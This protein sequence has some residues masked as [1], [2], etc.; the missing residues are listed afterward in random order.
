M[1]EGEAALPRQTVLVDPTESDHIVIHPR[2]PPSRF[3]AAGIGAALLCGA[4]LVSNEAI[5]R[6]LLDD[7]SRTLTWGATLFRVLLAIHGLA[8]LLVSFF[9]NRRPLATNT[10]EDRNSKMARRAMTR[11]SWTILVALTLVALALRFW[12]LNS[13][14]WLDEVLT[15]TEYVRLPFGEII[16]RFGSQNQHMLYSVLAR[17][18]VSALGESAWALRLPSVVFGI[19]SIWA[20]FLLGRR[21]VGEGEALFACA[22]MTVSYHHIWFSQN[23]RGYTGL[24]FFAILAT[25]LWIRARSEGGWTWWI[26]YSIAVALGMWTHMT[27]VFV[28]LTHALLFAAWLAVKLRAGGISA[29]RDVRNGLPLRPIIAWLLG[30]TITLQ[31]YALSLPDFLRQGLHEVSMP[32]EW[33]SPLWVISETLRSL[34]IGFSGAAVVLCGGM[35]VVVGW[36]SLAKKN[37]L[38]ALAITVPALLGAVTMLLMSHNL[39]PRFFFF[40]MGFGL[41]IVVHGTMTFP[42]LVFARMTFIGF[43][44]R[45]GK[46]TAPALAALLV[47][48]SAATVPRCYALPK[49]DFSGARDYVEWHRKPNEPVLAVGLAGIAYGRYFAPHWLIAQTRD[50]L[51]EVVRNHPDTWLVYTAPIEVKAFRPDL[52]KAIEK[53]FETDRVFPG[54]LGGGE[55]YVCRHSP[56][57][58]A[59]GPRN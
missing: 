48:A 3:I 18:S 31:L 53:E 21:M 14:L 5:E 56:V 44:D 10:S 54:T 23:A 39:W 26:A 52:W 15:L 12:S 46:L 8:L 33:T 13:E 43:H 32:S 37:L 17:V 38:Q 9:N 28:V 36:L 22:L 25:W 6:A 19:A 55:V 57:R 30:S 45:L 58:A 16:T 29:I 42:R 59:L 41:L 11:F 7:P 50:E 4:L 24:L 2:R 40:S 20:L 34:Q 27:M 35:M 49:Q 1:L 47:I 51:D